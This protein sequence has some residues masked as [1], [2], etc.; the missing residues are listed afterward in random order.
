MLCLNE[1]LS[2]V[3]SADPGREAVVFGDSSLTY[4]Q[5][6]E[7]ARRLAGALAGLGVEYGD[8]VAIWVPNSAEFMEMV[9]GVPSLGAIAVPLDYWWT[10]KDAFVALGQARPKVLIVGKSQAANLVEM[11]SEIEA[12]GIQHVISVEGTPPDG[13]LS[14]ERVL[15]GA[16]PL[17]EAVKVVQSHPALILF[18]SGST[19]RSKGAVHT[20]GDLSATAVIINLEVGVR[21][22]ERTLQFLP[23][24]SSCLEHMIPYTL[25]HAT[26]VIMPSFDAAMV[27]Q[28]IVRHGVTHFNAVPTTLRR[29]LEQVPDDIPQSL[30]LVSY[31]SEPMPAKLITD[32][33]ARLPSVEFVQIYG[34]IEHLCLTVQNAVEQK[35]KIGT[36][37]RPMIG[38][39][40]RILGPD[41][42]PSDGREPGEIL[43][44]SPTLF[45]GYWQDPE[46]TAQV[47]QDGWMRTGDIGYFDDEGFL[48]LS[49]RLKEVIKSGGVTVIPNEVEGALLAHEA[50]SE[51]AVVGI[52][53][54]QW[55]EAVHAFVVL[56][57]GVETTE[58]DLR[59][60]CRERMAGYKTPKAV[61][62]VADL[63][64]TGIGKIARRQVR[65]RY[66]REVDAEIAA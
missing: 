51:V 57:P 45:A 63:P 39:E 25:A 40:L 35:T 13:F 49:G 43:A 36:V 33:M 47:V 2:H 5:V 37:G 14:Y 38:A 23:M 46:T 19:G 34:M 62:F 50:V 1:I 61:H 11:K 54:E 4:A 26:H 15:A 41:G 30:R 48:V 10:P 53:D 29:I 59:A 31:A 66:L 64:R 24:Y 42:E 28:M 32:L 20:H 52:P 18:T 21:R 27:W 12:A 65:D 22:G 55:G 60:F 44:R 16:E 9:F 6:D 56:H 3:A 7:R 58:A 8:R 17:A